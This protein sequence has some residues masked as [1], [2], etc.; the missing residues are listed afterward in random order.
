MPFYVSE[1]LL[2]E[3]CNDLYYAS[4]VIGTFHSLREGKIDEWR[5]RVVGAVK[6]SPEA[7]KVDWNLWVDKAV[8]YCI[9]GCKD[10]CTP[11][12]KNPFERGRNQPL[13]NAKKRQWEDPPKGRRGR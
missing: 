1:A 2:E 12:P 3:W 11:N 8:A 10:R 13:W 6:S 7:Q 5:G 9:D 4:L